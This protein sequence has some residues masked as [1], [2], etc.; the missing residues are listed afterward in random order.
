MH[1]SSTEVKVFTE[2]S[3]HLCCFGSFQARLQ[4]Q[5]PFQ[6]YQFQRLQITHYRLS[7]CY[8]WDGQGHVHSFAAVEAAVLRYHY[9]S[10]IKGDYLFHMDPNL[11]AYAGILD[12]QSWILCL[13][14]RYWS[15]MTPHLRRKPWRMGNNCS[16]LELLAMSRDGNSNH[17]NEGKLLQWW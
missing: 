1:T 3:N 10:L 4:Q 13:I 5:L 17:T 16:W 9:Y 15:A 8:W 11:I 2:F 7:C 14:R 6:D 12:G